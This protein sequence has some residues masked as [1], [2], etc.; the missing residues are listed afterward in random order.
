MY[1]FF[2]PI[3]TVVLQNLAKLDYSRGGGAMIKV[4]YCV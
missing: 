2:M 3:V 1:S 4:D